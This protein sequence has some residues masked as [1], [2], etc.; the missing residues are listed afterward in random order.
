LGPNPGLDARIVYN[1]RKRLAAF[2]Q[3]KGSTGTELEPAS[4]DQVETAEDLQALQ[5]LLDYIESEFADVTTQLD[6]LLLQKNGY[7][8]WNLLWML[9]ERGTRMEALDTEFG[10]PYAFELQGWVYKER[11]NR[12]NFAYVMWANTETELNIYM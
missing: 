10:E 7:T 2:I 4:D 12:E 11:S 6:G 5:L 9:C 1:K 3:E 8:T